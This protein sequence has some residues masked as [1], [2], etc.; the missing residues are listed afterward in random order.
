MTMGDLVTFQIS[1]GNIVTFR[2]SSPCPAKCPMV[3]VHSLLLPHVQNLPFLIRAGDCVVMNTSYLSP[4]RTIN[5]F[6]SVKP[7]A[8]LTKLGE[9]E[10]KI[11]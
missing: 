1:W 8:P 3:S 4:T 6:E 5:K 9:R 11:R 7:N 10:C 2:V